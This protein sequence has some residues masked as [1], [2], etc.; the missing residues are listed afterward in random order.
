MVLKPSEGA[1]VARSALKGLPGGG[2]AGDEEREQLSTRVLPGSRWSLYAAA[3]THRRTVWIVCALVVFFAIAGAGTMRVR[4]LFES[5]ATAEGKLA[6]AN[7]RLSTANERIEALAEGSAGLRAR[8]AELAG[9]VESVRA[10]KVRTIVR[11]RT[12]T[13]RV[14]KWVPNGE[15]VTVESTGFGN[16]IE[17]NDVHLTNSYGYSDLVG[18][19]TNKSGRVISYAELGCTFVDA[20]GAV[21]ANGIANRSSWPPGA[22]WGFDC[23]AEAEATGGI[24]R[25][26]QMN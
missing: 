13:K 3:T 26:H 25:V 10:S 21:V 8:V 7:E 18:V 9:E 1:T 5:R 20:D 12:V 6:V 4:E 24:L 23:A 16:D 22:S 11:T 17:I 2:D 14:P 19:A 15:G